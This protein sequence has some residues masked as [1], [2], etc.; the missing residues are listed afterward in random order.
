MPIQSGCHDAPEG[1]DHVGLGVAV[2]ADLIQGDLAVG[3]EVARLALLA[4]G[5]ADDEARPWQ[6]RQP[7]TA[8]RL[9]LAER[10]IPGE[11]GSLPGLLRRV[12]QAQPGLLVEEERI[13]DIGAGV[14]GAQIQILGLIGELLIVVIAVHDLDPAGERRLRDGVD[15]GG[16]G[17]RAQ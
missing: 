13:A 17:G 9:G 8:A 2:H 16:A 12:F 10:G 1:V 14:V 3:D 7:E 11:A 4:H 5:R 6:R 15:A